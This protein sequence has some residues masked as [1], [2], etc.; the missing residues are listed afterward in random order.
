MCD[1]V[2]LTPEKHWPQVT[3]GIQMHVHMCVC[4]CMCICKHVC[5]NACMYVCMTNDL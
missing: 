1:D 4:E 3:A 5:M 2:H